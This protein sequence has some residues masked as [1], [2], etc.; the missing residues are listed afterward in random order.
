MLD[1]KHK[2]LIDY[3]LIFNIVFMM[4]YFLIFFD[5]NLFFFYLM[6]LFGLTSLYLYN[7]KKLDYQAN[8]ND[9]AKFI[10]S[11]LFLLIFNI[12]SAV[13]LFIVSSKLDDTNINIT[14][15]SPKNKIDPEIKKLDILLK[16]GVG[17]VFIGIET[18]WESINSA[19]E[20]KR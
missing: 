20:I 17:M 12:V 4:V 19:Y 8:K 14:R 10:I 3:A 1:S 7:F 11:G 16:L 18:S 2:K 15:G 9:K 5:D 13:I 6:G